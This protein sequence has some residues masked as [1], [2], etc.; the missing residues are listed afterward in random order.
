MTTMLIPGQ[1]DRATGQVYSPDDRRFK[2]LRA[3]AAAL[4][5]IAAVFAVGTVGVVLSLGALRGQH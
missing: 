3:A 2:A 1:R 5:G 4:G